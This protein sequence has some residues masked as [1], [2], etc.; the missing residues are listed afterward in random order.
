MKYIVLLF[1]ILSLA[2][3]GKIQ[4]EETNVDEEAYQNPTP[5][6]EV[7]VDDGGTDLNQTL[8]VPF[9]EG[10]IVEQRFQQ[11]SEMYSSHSD[12]ITSIQYK[13]FV[14]YVYEVFDTYKAMEGNHEKELGYLFDVVIPRI[15]INNW[16]LTDKIDEAEAELI[17][18]SI[19][20]KDFNSVEYKKLLTEKFK[21]YM[22]ETRYNELIKGLTPE[23][24]EGLKDD[25]AMQ[26]FLFDPEVGVMYQVLSNRYNW[27]KTGI[28]YKPGDLEAEFV[29]YLDEKMVNIL[30]ILGI[31]QDR[32]RDL[33]FDYYG[34]DSLENLAK[35]IKQQLD[36]M[37]ATYP[38]EGNIPLDRYYRDDERDDI[39]VDRDT[40]DVYVEKL[41]GGD[42]AG[43]Y[44]DMEALRLEVYMLSYLGKDRTDLDPEQGMWSSQARSDFI[45][46]VYGKGLQNIFRLSRYLKPEPVKINLDTVIYQ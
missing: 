37:I 28:G 25:T 4:P 1:M 40:V 10:D 2:S 26:Q 16:V 18:Q 21:I 23:K 42:V 14:G 12:L 32:L 33:A 17:I 34:V 13:E 24:L 6:E 38:L 30:A 29:Q 20:R 36:T 19:K 27:N 9:P 44:R 43:F 35:S 3:C 5:V 41:S 45:D 11:I 8:D 39:F 7:A 31:T 15:V 46:P 22:E